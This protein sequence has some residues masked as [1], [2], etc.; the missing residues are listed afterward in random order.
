MSPGLV[1]AM[2]DWDVDKRDIGPIGNL[3]LPTMSRLLALLRCGSCRFAAFYFLSFYVAILDS[4]HGGWGWLLFSALIWL[5]HSL[6]TELVNRV[7]DETEDRINRPERTAMCDL[8]GYP[9]L[10]LLS[11]II[12]SVVAAI[13]LIWVISKPN[14]VV[15]VL[16][17]LAFMS[18]VNYSYGAR[19]KER[20]YLS[21]LALTFPF[22]G[23]FL[24]GWF[25]YHPILESPDSLHILV[26]RVVP[27][28][29]IMGLLIGSIASAKDITDI[30]GDE[31]VGYLSVAV[32]LI[33]KNAVL[34]ILGMVSIPFLAIGLSVS[35]GLL[36]F[37]FSWLLFF[38]PVSL[39]GAL[40]INAATGEMELMAVKEAVYHYWFV[41]LAVSL[42]LYLPAGST[43][44]VIFG[45]A[46]YWFIGSQYLHW[47]DGIRIW[48]IRL[49]FTILRRVRLQPVSIGS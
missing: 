18:G 44:L 27:F 49:L 21:L 23:P 29:T 15:G 42:Y 45:T 31:M 16:L 48:K 40:C 28:V 4:G 37:R 12:W 17:A 7:S 20:R 33:R 11:W 25:V 14:P 26:G 46:V 3:E 1:K 5:L 43:L 34:V 9:R 6:G 8:I 10:R 47:T 36:P 24:V 35:S 32:S 19:F 39:L 2:P 22:A 38:M 13:D 41:L 30:R